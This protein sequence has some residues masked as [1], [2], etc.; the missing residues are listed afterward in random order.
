MQDA[1]Q[2][3]AVSGRSAKIS[4]GAL[5]SGGRR[6]T[7]FTFTQVRCAGLSGGMTVSS[8]GRVPVFETCQNMPETGVIVI[9]P[10]KCPS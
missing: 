2:E 7:K 10:V 1:L 5:G 8:Y 4:G 9:R 6:T 3:L